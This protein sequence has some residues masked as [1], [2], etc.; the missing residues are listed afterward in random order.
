MCAAKVASERKAHWA[1]GRGGGGQRLSLMSRK[2]PKRE[3]GTAHKG[4]K[5]E[6]HQKQKVVGTGNRRLNRQS[7][8]KPYDA[9]R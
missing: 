6:Q 1:S 2:S 3:G 7:Q 4:K 9:A 8:K 5:E